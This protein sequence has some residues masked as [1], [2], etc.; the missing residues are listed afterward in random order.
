MG[1]VAITNPTTIL[2]TDRFKDQTAVVTGGASGI[3]RAIARRLAI[4]GGNVHVCERSPDKLQRARA[5]FGR[6]GLRVTTVACDISEEASVTAAFDR[7]LSDT[8]RLD[9]V[10]HSAGI[11]GPTHINAVE[12]PTAE[13]DRVCTI[14]LHGS[15]LVAKHAIARMLANRCGRLLLLASMAGKEGNPGMIGYS[16]SKAGVFGLVKALGKEYAESGITINGLAPALIHTPLVDGMQPGQIAYMAARIPMK[17]MG[18]VE[19]VAALAC[20]IVSPEATFNT[21]FVFDLSG[22]RAT[23]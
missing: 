3:G 8:N 21:G 17:R 18:T 22:G 12:Y 4:E 5:D 10:V 23:Y 13:F 20:W 16:A 14:N 1:L 15:F 11:V 19:E 2:F 9:V 6:E 7:I